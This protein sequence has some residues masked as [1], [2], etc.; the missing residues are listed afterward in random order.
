MTQIMTTQATCFLIGVFLPFPTPFK[1]PLITSCYLIMLASSRSPFPP[2][3]LGHQAYRL[4]MCHI[5]E[6]R[7]DQEHRAAARPAWLPSSQVPAEG[8]PAEGVPAEGVLVKGGASCV[9]RMAQEI[10]LPFCEPLGGEEESSRCGPFVTCAAGEAAAGGV[11]AASAASWASWLRTPESRAPRLV[12]RGVEALSLGLGDP[13]GTEMPPDTPAGVARLLRD[14]GRCGEGS[15]VP[16]P[17]HTGPATERAVSRS[18]GEGEAPPGGPERAMVSLC[19]DCRRP[20]T[21][22]PR[23]VTW[24]GE[25]LSA[26]GNMCPFSS[27]V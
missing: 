6:L 19:R 24:L 10:A 15:P 9:G 16:V 21:A 4:I 7:L 11:V 13:P 2:H 12:P 22:F 18:R 23:A 14:K 8:V 25:W 27:V 17:P 20:S 26:S 5:N 3:G 1:L